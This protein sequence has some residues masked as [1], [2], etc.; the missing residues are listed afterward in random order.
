MK[1]CKAGCIDVRNRRLD[2]ERCVACMNCGAVCRF[3]AIRFGRRPEKEVS[4]EEPKPEVDRGRRAF[5]AAA[6][7][8]AAL[9]L[10]GPGG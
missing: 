10:A 8:S 2:I 1:V 4:P 6:G 9:A 5:L 7:I 3:G